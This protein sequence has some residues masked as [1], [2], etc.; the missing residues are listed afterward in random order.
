MSKSFWKFGSYT[1]AAA[2]AGL[3]GLSLVQISRGGP[4][5]GVDGP[6]RVDAVAKSF[7]TAPPQSQ[8]AVTFR[9][10]NRGSTPIRIVGATYTCNRHACL[11]GLD[12]PVEIPAG[13]SRPVRIGVA[14]YNP[15][16]SSRE[17]TLYTDAPGA[18]MLDLT[19]SGRVAEADKVVAARSASR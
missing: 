17:I 18:S 7:G 5:P 14:T 2:S 4:V 19:I 11:R 12:L 1:F 10:T 6:L 3:L 15:G 8:L 13:E 9:M 16:E